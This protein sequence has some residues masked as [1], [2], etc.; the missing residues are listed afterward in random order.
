MAYATGRFY[1]P[2]HIVWDTGDD[3]SLVESQCRRCG[4]TIIRTLRE[5]AEERLCT[6]CRCSE[7][8]RGN[9]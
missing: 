7:E 8:R 1:R 9:E 2:E 4:D 6:H 3:N 5:L